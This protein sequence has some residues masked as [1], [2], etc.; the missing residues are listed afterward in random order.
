MCN[1]AL[2]EALLV[3]QTSGIHEKQQ[4]PSQHEI[5]L[6]LKSHKRSIRVASSCRNRVTRSLN[7]YVGAYTTSFEAVWTLNM[8]FGVSQNGSTYAANIPT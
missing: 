1:M 8:A 6:I 4:F 7:T 2:I 5:N 3:P